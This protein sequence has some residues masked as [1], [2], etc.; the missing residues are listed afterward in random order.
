VRTGAGANAVDVAELAMGLMLAV[1]RQL[2]QG[3]RQVREQAWPDRITPTAHRISGRRLGIAGMGAI[4]REVGRLAV[5]FGMQVAYFARRPADVPW[6]FEPELRRLALA[7]DVLVIALP[8]APATHHLV[9]AAVLDALGP[10]GILVNVGRGSIVDER[11]LV[12]AL[13]GGRL[14]GAGLDVFEE[15]PWVPASLRE[16]HRVVLTP[17]RGGLTF[18]A[19]ESLVR[20]A[21]RHLDSHFRER[22]AFQQ[23]CA[24]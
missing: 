21:A 22:V 19:F 20:L 5:A 6:H 16:D 18:E 15:E 14:G 1:G 7:S 2:L 8:S 12:A 17:H 23:G 3:D 11:A 9:D 10:D 24:E 4:G 13:Q